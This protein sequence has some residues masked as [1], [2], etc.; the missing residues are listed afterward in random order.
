MGFNTGE[1]IG[2][3]KLGVLLIVC[4]LSV[5][6]IYSGVTTKA[7]KEVAEELVELLGKKGMKEF[8]SEIGEKLAK[9][10]ME[11]IVEKVLKE[12]GEE[13]GERLLKIAA[14][15]GVGALRVLDDV[16]PSLLKT[17]GS[18][19]DE[20]AEIVTKLLVRNA[21]EVIEI[22]AKAGKEGLEAYARNPAVIRR[23]VDTFGSDIAELSVS[24]L[25]SETIQS[26]AH[27]STVIR[28]AT[29][30]QKSTLITFINENKN[31]L[32]S[33]VAI[34]GGVVVF[35]DA[36]S[37]EMT[38]SPDGTISQKTGFLNET[39]AQTTK[40]AQDISQPIGEGLKTVIIGAGFI[41]LAYGMFKLVRRDIKK[42]RRKKNKDEECFSTEDHI[43]HKTQDDDL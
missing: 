11:E 39:V 41:L 30:A 5:S 17:M 1:Y 33:T 23:L 9:E 42:N 25:P 28:G 20:S 29:K 27:H 10:G 40:V 15:T 14:K 13:A 8:S 16:P 43:L 31:F 32:L 22:A 37:T 7:V 4:V 26:L 12:S 36:V 24:T 35:K 6:S 2:M 38:I 19:G 3:K 34:V 18:L 21:D